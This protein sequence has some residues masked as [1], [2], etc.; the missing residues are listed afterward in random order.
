ME[1]TL[2]QSEVDAI[3]MF[4]SGKH[5][6]VFGDAVMSAEDLSRLIR[7]SRVLRISQ[8]DGEH[9]I[10]A[11]GTPTSCCTLVLDGHVKVKAGL[12]GFESTCGPWTMFGL[13]V[14]EEQREITAD[15]SAIVEPE[16][17]GCRLLQMDLPN[18]L[19][20]ARGGMSH[21][22]L[23]SSNGKK[24]GLRKAWSL[25]KSSSHVSP[26]DTPESTSPTIAPSPLRRH[27]EGG[28][29]DVSEAASASA[30]QVSIE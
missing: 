7:S 3:T 2:P 26:S 5:K 28:L 13:R 25:V 11:A 6:D 9:G 23:S 8:E 16:S 14:L 4:L 19:S 1:R 27:T 24:G 22:Q 18:F 15:W 21:L 10:Y 29:S 30:V 12:D 20:H 17:S